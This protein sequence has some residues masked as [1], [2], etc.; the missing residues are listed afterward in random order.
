MD[1][2]GYA[3]SNSSVYETIDYDALSIESYNIAITLYDGVSRNETVAQDYLDQNI[4][5]AYQQLMKGGYRLFYTID[6]IFGSASSSPT[7]I[8]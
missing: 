8:E 4:P 1:T 2:Y 5:V 6:F 3:I 7:E